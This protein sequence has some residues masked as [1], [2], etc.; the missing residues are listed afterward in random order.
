ML[1]GFISA[2]RATNSVILNKLH[3]DDN[4]SKLALGSTQLFSSS[5]CCR[6]SV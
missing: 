4:P 3:L 6:E 1:H 2:I 5:P